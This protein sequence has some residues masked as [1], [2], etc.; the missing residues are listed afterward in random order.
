VLVFLRRAARIFELCASTS[1]GV[2]G[3][4]ASPSVPSL[5]N[6]ILFGRKDG[7]C[8]ESFEDGALAHA[9]AEVKKHRRSWTH[10][11]A[12]RSSKSPSKI[13]GS[14]ARLKFLRLFA[15]FRKKHWHIIFSLLFR[16]G[17]RDRPKGAGA[18]CPSPRSKQGQGKVR[19]PG[20]RCA[21][22]AQAKSFCPVLLPSETTDRAIH[23]K[24]CDLRSRSVPPLWASS[25]KRGR[26]GRTF[27]FGP[28][29]G[30]RCSETK[31]FLCCL[32]SLCCLIDINLVQR[33]G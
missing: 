22:Q 4:N 25:A 27:G 29:G 12:P 5:W 23:R 20:R 1:E 10:V 9:G 16:F 17:H 32:G 7:L 15:H 28:D 19:E 24:V 11:Q 33:S 18:P 30:L 31:S 21:A 3:R 13:A 6:S 14:R 26:N 2:F 8:P